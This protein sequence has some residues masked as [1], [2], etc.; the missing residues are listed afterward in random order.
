MNVLLTVPC[1]GLGRLAKMQD[2]SIS[3]ALAESSPESASSSDLTIGLDF[4]GPT[5]PRRLPIEA[6]CKY[7]GIFRE[8]LYPVWPVVNIDDLIAQ[9][10]LDVND[11]ESY[12]LAASVCAAAIA[13][14]RLPE[15]TDSCEASVSSW[16]F[17][18]DAQSVRELY[19]HRECHNL[20]SILT[21]FFLHIY[22]ANASKI[23]TAAVYLRESIASVHWLGL[24][25]QETYEPL[26]REE[27][28]L[29]LRIFWILFISER[30]A[31][32][33]TPYLDLVHL[34][35]L[36]GRTFCAQNCFPAVLVPIDEM[37]PYE[38]MDDSFRSI[39]QAFSSLTR[40][41]SHLQ[42]NILET[43]STRRPV[44][45]PDKVTTAQTDLCAHTQHSSFTEVQQV[46]L[47]VTRQWIRLLIWEYTMRHYK[48]SRDSTNQAFS[49]LLPVTIARELLSLFPSVSAES[50]YA[51][52][53]GMVS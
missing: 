24:D 3:T 11:L 4:V 5:C 18:R 23:R 28:S 47:F 2:V 34:L 8:R 50:I 38:E 46:D 40:L 20:S 37:P 45:D 43:S 21:P 12:A 27:R 10:I 7:L 22:F 26:E 32:F 52:G 39:T 35:T 30:Q 13:Q 42:S 48:M 36:H 44:M 25:R 29:K 14:L 51:H 19:D 1:L 9:L 17:A 33:W 53:Y 31:G 49:L 16:Q 6:Y 15:H 41:F